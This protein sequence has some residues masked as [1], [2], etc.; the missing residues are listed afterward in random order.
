[1]ATVRANFTTKK[2]T[3]L[4][5]MNLKGK[6]Y[7]LAA[8]RIQW[9]REEN[10]DGILRTTLIDQGGEGK[11][12]YYVIK[13]EVVINTDKGQ[14]L[15]ATAHKRESVADFPDAL[16]KCETSALARALALSGYGVQFT[17]DELEEGQRL[18]DA[19]L[20]TP[21]TKTNKVIATKAPTQETAEEQTAPLSET[22]V[23]AKRPT[24][25]RARMKRG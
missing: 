19:P 20:E 23:E 9:F 24:P 12:R 17:G 11:D 14:Q 15:I 5:L 21:T 1:M 10:P 6:E 4:P 16:E 18:A 2:G 7:L 8:H 22:K 25:F 13:A 3:T